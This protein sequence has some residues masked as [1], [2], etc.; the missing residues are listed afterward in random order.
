MKSLYTVAAVSIVMLLSACGQAQEE[1][2]STSGEDASMEAIDVEIDMPGKQ[3]PETEIEIA[4]SVTQGNDQVTD[5]D[6]V[7]F[8]IW[9]EGA[10]ENSEEI[11]A[12]DRENNRY[13]ISKT[14]E[15]DGVYHVTAHVTARD[16]HNMPTEEIIIGDPETE[17]N[18]EHE[19]TDHEEESSALETNLQSENITVG[20][21]SDITFEVNYEEEPLTDA[22]VRYEIQKSDAE[23]QSWVDAEET[24]DG[25]YTGTH[26]F[27]AAGEYRLT[28]HVENEEDLHEH[29]QETMEVE[30]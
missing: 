17:K 26:I 15:E 7:R 12:E 20:E 10:K 5:A 29:Q 4:A 8:E 14:F 21:P 27:E 6:E 9:K 11:M 19:S 3:E 1:E 25:V 30:E 2:N 23:T 13:S 28:V 22:R 24:D 18:E 16:M